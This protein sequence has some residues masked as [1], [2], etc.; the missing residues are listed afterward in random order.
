MKIRSESYKITRSRGWIDSNTLDA[1]QIFLSGTVATPY[2]I[3]CIPYSCGGTMWHGTRLD[4]VHAGRSYTKF[5]DRCY[6][7]RGLVT[8]SVRFAR[9][10]V[11]A[12]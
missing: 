3:V 9:D 10:I 6:S 7:K 8:A 12:K 4:F 2:G 1:G 11:K 5:I